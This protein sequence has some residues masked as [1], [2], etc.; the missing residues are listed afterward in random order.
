MIHR[1]A[2]LR[3]ADRADLSDWAQRL[4]QPAA[5]LIEAGSARL[6]LGVWAADYDAVAAEMEAFVRPLWGL[7]PLLAGGGDFAEAD[8]F[9]QGIAA[10]TDP[11]HPDYWGD[12]GPSDQRM[13]EMAG[14]AMA[15]LLAPDRFW[16]PLGPDAQHRAAEWMRQIND[17]PPSD[18]NW[19]FFRVLVNLALANLGQDWSRPAVDDALRRI[20]EFHLGD[21]WYRDG[22]R[23]QIDYYTPMAFHFYGL[24]FAQLGGHLFPEHGQ[25]YRARARNFAQSFQFFFDRDGSAIPFGRSMTYR[26]AQSA[27]WA[28]CAFAN[29]EVLPWPQIKGLLLRNLRWWARQPI[30][31]R[32]GVLTVGYAYPNPLMGEGYNGPGAPYWA[33]KPLLVLALGADHPFWQADEEPAEALRDGTVICRGAGFQVQ[34]VQGRASLLTGGQDARQFR[35]AEPKYGGFAYASGFGFSV[36]S[37][38]TAPERRDMVAMESGLAISRD[39]RSWL[40]RGRIRESGV[41]DGMIWGRWSPD[42]RLDVQTWSLFSEKGWHLRLHVLHSADPLSVL[43]TG[44]AINAMGGTAPQIDRDDGRV[45]LI[46]DGTASALVDPDGTRAAGYVK[47]APNTNILHPRTIIPEL[48]GDLSAGKHVLV[49]AVFGGATSDGQPGDLASPPMTPPFRDVLNRVRAPA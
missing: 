35:G 32:S 43:E 40:R 8:T 38:A 18:N 4:I 41:R 44:F 15:W 47:A 42:D 26:M 17:Q 14:I 1:P 37:D 19:L 29:E 49:T 25:R 22:D 23:H 5:G 16:V 13:V 6:D 39:G 45:C 11:A 28:A 27:F 48:T 7:A 46:G 36:P 34:R 30:C 10:G 2:P 31:D 33:L 24:I 3:L 12:V 9:C 21:G 20:D